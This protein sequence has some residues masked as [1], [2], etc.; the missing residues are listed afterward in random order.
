ME[1]KKRNPKTPTQSVQQ[2]AVK[3]R[4]P[5]VFNQPV[6]RTG[7]RPGGAQ[8]VREIAPARRAQRS[9]QLLEVVLVGKRRI[10][11]EPLRHKQLCRR[12]LRFPAVLQTNARPHECLRRLA[13]R[14]DAEAERHSERH[15]AL[16]EINL[17]HHELHRVSSDSR[18]PLMEKI[19]V[20]ARNSRNGDLTVRAGA[21][22]SA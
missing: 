20:G 6:R 18:I 11:V 13:Q 9:P 4:R 22:G 2:R 15:M 5:E 8:A 3:Q 7:M 17:I 14:D 16:E 10:L 1:E 21:C 19:G 12:A